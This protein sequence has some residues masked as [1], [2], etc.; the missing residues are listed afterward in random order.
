MLAAFHGGSGLS[1]AAFSPDRTQPRCSQS[2]SQNPVRSPTPNLCWAGPQCG[3]GRGFPWPRVNRKAMPDP[4]DPPDGFLLHTSAK[5][6]F[7]WTRGC[8]PAVMEMPP[9]CSHFVIKWRPGG[10]SGS[11]CVLL[12]PQSLLNNKAPVGQGQYTEG[13]EEEP[14]RDLESHRLSDDGKPAPGLGLEAPV[15]QVK[16]YD[17]CICL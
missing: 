7:S 6:T 1:L 10:P 16:F 17:H 9:V 15:D 11:L 8:H 14:G 3:G 4:D 12:L 2:C 5:C 13:G